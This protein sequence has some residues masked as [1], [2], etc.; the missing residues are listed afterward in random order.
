M[1]QKFKVGEVA[2]ISSGSTYVVMYGQSLVQV[3]MADV[4][5]E[6]GLSRVVKSAILLEG[7]H[8]GTYIDN[9]AVCKISPLEQLAACSEGVEDDCV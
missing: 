5:A 8:K 4:W 7:M 2:R 9:V 6:E 1:S 3:D